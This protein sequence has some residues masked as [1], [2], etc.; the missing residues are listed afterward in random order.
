MS[1]LRDLPSVDKLLQ[2]STAARLIENYGRPQTLAAIRQTL[3]EV[4]QLAAGGIPLPDQTS[5]L[6]SAEKTLE[7]WFSPTL[8]PVINASGVIL[9]TNLGRAPLSKAALQAQQEISGG[10]STLEFNLET[11]RRS[12]REI[13]AEKLLTRLTGGEAALVVNNNAAA[14]LL[15]L[16][17]LAW[18]KK[19]VI[20]R[21]QLVEIG[22][23]FR[24][25]EVMKQSGAKL[26][27][28]G[29]TNRVHLSD[30]ET[31]LD[32]WTPAL[33]LRAHHSNFRIIGFTSEPGLSE[34]AAAAH[35]RGV[36]LIDDL[37]S[38]ALLDTEPFGLAHEPTVQE[39][40]AAGAD[41]VCFSGDKLL[42]GPQAGVIVGSRVL[43]DKIRKHPLARAVRADKS[44]LAA[45]AATLLHYLKD[46]A[47]AEIPVW[48]M[49]S[50]SPAELCSRAE[51][52]V[53]TLGQGE[54]VQS[55]STVGGGSLPEE[56]LPTYALAL[57]VPQPNQ[58]LAALRA[59]RPAV[60][61]RVENDRLLFDPRTVLPNQDADLLASLKNAL[62]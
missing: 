23:G 59:Q 8:I 56:T 5:L 18:R 62:K 12:K 51:A 11:G 40:L 52:W 21:T 1:D 16:S 27:E 10:Y 36:P 41:L 7:E 46:E 3:D 19:V 17:A 45:L 57:A 22:G 25:P 58:F 33:V 14:V 43:V 15:I 34:I 49:I 26:V 39:S 28:I 2:T 35:A 61:A 60:I 44:C 47:L 4:R 37:G 13:H 32:E 20:S 30:Y 53:R 31:A 50:A 38:G 9:H 55:R 29:T 54:V 24:V 48:R 42:G 6:T